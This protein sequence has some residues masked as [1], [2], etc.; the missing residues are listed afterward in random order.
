MHLDDRVR[1]E[2]V[3]LAMQ[4]RSHGGLVWRFDE[5]E[6]RPALLVE[7][8]DQC[9]ARVVRLNSEIL[10][11]GCRDGFRGGISNVVAVHE[12]GHRD[13]PGF[14][15]VEGRPRARHARAALRETGRPSARAGCG[16]WPG[17][18]LAGVLP[19]GRPSAPAC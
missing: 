15:L 17:V 7:P 3:R 18:S 5:A 13:L 8:V 4:Q 14:G 11:M 19:A 9:L 16:T 2:A 1:D 10:L 6:G 12:E